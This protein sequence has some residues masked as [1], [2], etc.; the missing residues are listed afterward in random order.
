MKSLTD[1]LLNYGAKFSQTD[2]EHLMCIEAAA[3]IERLRERCEAYKGQVKW[4][5]DVIAAQQDGAR[6]GYTLVP[7]TALE[8]LFG[9]G[10]DSDGKWFGESEGD[11]I[12]TPRKYSRRYWWRTKFRQ[13]ITPEQGVPK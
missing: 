1:R 7:N 9:S 8:W 4:G 12:E 6:E 3:E 11:E 2:P 13:L 5:A 10:P